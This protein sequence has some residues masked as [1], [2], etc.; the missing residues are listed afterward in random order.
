MGKK[1]V[2]ITGASSGIGASTAVLL[3]NDYRLVLCG[4]D[5]DRLR[6]TL[7]RCL[8]TDHIIWPFDLEYVDDITSSLSKLIK[9]N[10]IEIY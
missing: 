7:N 9:E 6:Q 3:S 4:R 1:V 5:E 2:L 10:K 8:G